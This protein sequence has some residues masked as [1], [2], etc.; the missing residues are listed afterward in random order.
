LNYQAFS[1]HA[2]RNSNPCATIPCTASCA[3]PN[4]WCYSLTCPSK[5]TYPQKQHWR[6]LLATQKTAPVL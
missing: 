3:H 1:L 4:I 6:F 2:Q 5:W